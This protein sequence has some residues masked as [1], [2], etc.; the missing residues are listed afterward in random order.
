MRLCLLL[1]CLF[2]GCARPTH[3]PSGTNPLGSTL[4]MAHKLVMWDSAQAFADGESRRL[5]PDGDAVRMHHPEPRGFPLRSTW[6][7]PTVETS[8]DFTELLPSWNAI[9]PERTGVMF[10][11]RARDARTGDWSPWLYTGFW[12][13]TVGLNRTIDF[14]HGKVEVDVLVL[15]RPAN[16]FE[17]RATMLSFDPAGQ[18]S[19]TLRRVAAVYSREVKDET[20]RLA[21][22]GAPER[23]AADPRDLPLIFR[24]QGL[25]PANL[26]SEIC[27][28]TST[29]MVMAY[30]GVDVPMVESALTVY[31]PE[32]DLFGNWNRAVQF[33]GSMGLDAWLERFASMDDVRARISAGQP[34]IA[35]I[36]FGSGEFP[37][38]VMDATAGHLIVIRGFNAEGDAIVNDPASRDRGEGIVYKADE[39]ARAWF[40]G[41]G[42][43]AYIIRTPTI[44]SE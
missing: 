30:A 3:T 24:A 21:L 7:S 31:D 8:F 27:S 11:V 15:D 42:G 16:A 18:V 36:R 23:I 33:A 10:H 39:L 41:A 9:V 4:P 35:S 17:V 32:Y 25:A 20:T 34:V 28:P 13:Q 37:S 19:P 5:V 14:E 43:V 6:T 12:G 2:A 40:G 38:N 22:V 1:L 44:E 29:S 26:K